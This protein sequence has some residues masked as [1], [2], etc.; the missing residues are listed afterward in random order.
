[1]NILEGKGGCIE[2]DKRLKRMIPYS[3][4]YY[5][6]TDLN[7][8]FL[9]RSTTVDILAIGTNCSVGWLWVVVSS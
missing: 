1:M 6:K 4:G 8:R 3:F 2:S 9:D 7:P 5:N